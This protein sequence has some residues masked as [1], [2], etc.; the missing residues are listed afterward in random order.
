[1]LARIGG[2]TYVMEA[3]RN[4]TCGSL[5]GG[6]RP[7]VATAMMKYNM[8]ELYRKVVNDGLDILGGNAI[9]KG[10]RNLLAAHY[11]GA[12]IFITV[13]GANILTRTLIIFGQ[14]A[15]RCHP[16]VYREIQAIKS[17]DTTEFDHALW[18]HVGHGGA[19]LF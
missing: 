6:A 11:I 14:G 18:G 2:I 7:A 17:G 5:D 15:I 16:Y 13:E 3:A 8:T 19:Q 1:L 4:Y 10:P 12:P 9:M